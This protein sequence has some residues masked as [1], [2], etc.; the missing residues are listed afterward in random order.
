AAPPV[1]PALPP[2]G[3]APEI[4]ASPP[5]TGF[6]AGQ[7]Q[8][9][10]VPAQGDIRVITDADGGADVPI[11]PGLRA[12][13]A[14]VRI[15]YDDDVD[16]YDARFDVRP[17]LRAPIVTGV[18]TGGIGAVPGDPGTQA[19]AEYEA[20]ARRGLVALYASG[21]VTDR[22]AATLAYDTAGNLDENGSFGSFDENPDSRPYLTYG[23]SSQRRDDALS[24]NHLYA[25]IEQGNSNLGYDEFQATT[26]D[27]SQGSLGGFNLLVNG[28]HGT[29][30]TPGLKVQA[31]RATAG[32][33]YGRQVI[34]PTGL[35]SIAYDLHPNVVVGS[36]IL[37]LV[38]I[39]RHA[40]FI[41]S[42]TSLQRNV[43][44]VID[45]GTGSIRFI[46]PPLAY[47]ASFN[48]QQILVQ[49]EYEGAN[50]AVATGGSASAKLGSVVVGAGYANDSTGTGNVTLFGQNA[51]API[52]GGTLHLEH[53]A[54]N[55][56]IG[57]TTP[58]VGQSTASSDATNGGSF[59]LGATGGLGTTRYDLV[60][61]TTSAG[62][63]DPFGGI[64]T[65]GLST[66]RLSLTRP[67]TGGDVA[68]LADAEG[69][70][71]YGARSSDTSASV[72]VHRKIGKRLKT[73]VAVSHRIVSN[74][75]IS[76]PAGFLNAGQ[77]IDPVPSVQTPEPAASVASVSYGGGVT[78][79]EVG[80]TYAF[81]PAIEGSLDRVSDIGG[82]TLASASSPSQ[83][84][85]QLAALLG[86]G[87]R[88]YLREL[89][90]GSA[91][92]SFAT[93]TQPLTTAG[94]ATHV[95]QIGFDR[96]IGPATTIDTQYGV[97]SGGTGSDVYSAIGVKERI[98][99]TKRLKGD[100]TVQHATSAGSGGDGFNQ[101]G[102]SLAYDGGNAFKAT[103]AYQFR[104]GATPGSSLQ[105]GAIGY[106]VS[107]VSL[108]AS[109]NDVNAAGIDTEDQRVGLAFRPTYDDDSSILLG[110]QHLVGVG[111]VRGE[112]TNV[113]SLDALHRFSRYTTL[114]G[115]VAY[116]ID[117]D[118]YYAAHTALAG[119]RVVQSVAH[120]F[121]VA[122]ELRA[123]GIAG[124]PGSSE[125][126]YAAEIGYRIADQFR[127]A[128]GWNFQQTPD[129]S[130]AAPPRR[131]GI[132]VTAT[133]VLNSLLGFGKR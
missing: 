14:V 128:A 4:F 1:V 3:N 90:T 21:Q 108:V 17:Y 29:Y 83:T 77:A 52:P 78:Q 46:N 26:G 41:V 117:G 63:D 132:Y 121:D 56:G 12:G 25:R 60:Y 75:G 66:L 110:Y 38:A 123:S 47:D 8:P 27:D 55:G 81:S 101:Y 11:V 86:K 35:A 62:F 36:E 34:A 87:G 113:A 31:F 37:T 91:T 102:V 116:Q 58:D 93:S 72:R 10:G 5:P 68:F 129:T 67:I 44:Y 2:A 32:V 103:T 49:Y 33:A 88:A 61:Q 105:L 115:R 127:L 124:V 122:G 100:V 85:A 23:D 28:A 130:L 80:A 82:D 43:D 57:N 65:P 109:A 59:R 89:W 64:A 92:Q 16:S 20:N 24:T 97:E 54:T 6:A 51:S 22:A 30:A 7:A 18:V 99:A 94:G 13:E 133:S 19:T 48:P 96:Q 15:A 131:K 114:T 45:Y 111:D 76:A 120:R 84:S 119:L 40:G 106:I 69:N 39:D 53:L 95:T 79:A 98:F 9:L 112:Q 107:G 73:T 71:L 118:Q 70:A 104:T 126:G 74:N 50:G 125:A 42:E